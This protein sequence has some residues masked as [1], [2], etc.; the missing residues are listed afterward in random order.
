MRLG[1]TSIGLKTQRSTTNTSEGSISKIIGIMSQM[2]PNIHN[3]YKQIKGSLEFPI[4]Y[5]TGSSTKTYS[6]PSWPLGTT[7]DRWA[8]K[9]TL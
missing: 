4:K 7:L 1:S 8:I 5:P 6:M 9:L 3:F 2:T